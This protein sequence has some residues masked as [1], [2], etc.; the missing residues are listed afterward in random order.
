MM[1]RVVVAS[2]KSTG[3]KMETFSWY[4]DVRESCP[5]CCNINTADPSVLGPFFTDSA[6]RRLVIGDWAGSRSQG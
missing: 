2:S 3:V 6:H 5:S 4:A 1:V